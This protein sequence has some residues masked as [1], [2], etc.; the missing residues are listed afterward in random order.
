MI[1][2]DQ[3]QTAAATT[4][5]SAVFSLFTSGATLVCCALPAAL[6]ALGAG[7]ALSSLLAFLPLLKWISDHA[8]TVLLIA[9]LM[10]ALGGALQ[11]QQWHA[12]CP[13]DTTQATACRRLRRS[14][15][16]V[17]IFSVGIFFVGALFALPALCG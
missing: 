9:A 1:T 13:T 2:S 5:L 3:T 6:V 14:S 16:R 11:W 8:G 12:P 4:C 10:L 17:Y 15:L 7:A